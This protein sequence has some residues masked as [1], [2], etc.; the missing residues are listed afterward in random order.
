MQC[1]LTIDYDA[2]KLMAEASSISPGEEQGTD[3]SEA[4]TLALKTFKASKEEQRLLILI[5][6][7]ED[8]EK[9]W[10]QFLPAIKDQNIT[11]FTVGIG[12]TGGAPIPIKDNQGNVT[13]WKKDKKG[14]IVKTRLD[15]ETLVKIASETGG[16]YFRLADTTAADIFIDN[17]KNFERTVL[18]KK[19]K[20]QKIKRF[21]IPL[22]IGILILLLELLLSER[23]LSWKEKK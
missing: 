23:T 6:D 2:F 11:V 7:G 10:Q 9:T 18:R 20:K 21:H 17:L 5:T 19:V 1:P 13:G 14:E 15:E 12:V 16:Q 22:I 4:F 3:F 8:Q